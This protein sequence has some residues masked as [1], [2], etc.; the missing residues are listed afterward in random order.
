MVENHLVGNPM[1]VHHV[2]EVGAAEHGDDARKV[3]GLR[4]V[5]GHEAAPRDVAAREGD[6][7]RSGHGDVVHVLAVPGQEAAVFRARHPLADEPHPY[8]QR[9]SSIA[10]CHARSTIAAP[11]RLR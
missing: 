1:L 5:D 2:V 3:A 11:T 8:H 4:D 7:Q 9:A 10:S 6:M